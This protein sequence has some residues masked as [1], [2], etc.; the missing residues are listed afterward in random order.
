MFFQSGAAADTG[1][2][3]CVGA[4]GEEV[5]E[6]GVSVEIAEVAV[7]GSGEMTGMVTLSVVV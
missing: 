7:A 3:S 5:E 6:R 4:V 1:G 2:L